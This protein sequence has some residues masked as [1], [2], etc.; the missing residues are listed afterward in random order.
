MN[1][2]ASFGGAPTRV[3][4]VRFVGLNGGSGEKALTGG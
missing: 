1:C 3:E 4:A 2:V